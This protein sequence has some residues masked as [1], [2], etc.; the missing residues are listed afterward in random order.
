[1]LAYDLMSEVSVPK[2]RLPGFDGAAFTLRT[3]LI[4]EKLA[5]TGGIRMAL[6]IGL[7]NPD[8]KVE[9]FAR[10]I[11]TE[12]ISNLSDLFWRAATDKHPELS[13]PILNDESLGLTFAILS[14][15]DFRVEIQITLVEDLN[16]NVLEFDFLN[17]ETS[18]IALTSA[19]DDVRTLDGSE[20]EFS[21][22]EWIEP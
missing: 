7:L 20:R 18:R 15:T 19:A 11:E 17:F 22:E 8:R 1:M 10:P 5:G 21:H 9:Y 16:A 12:T 2:F 14:S 4:P 3:L 6:D 13:V